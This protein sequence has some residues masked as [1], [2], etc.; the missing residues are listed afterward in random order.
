LIIYL[1]FKVTTPKGL[2]TSLKESSSKYEVAHWLEELARTTSTFKLAGS[3]PL[4]LEQTD[5]KVAKYLSYRKAHFKTLLTQYINLVGF[6]II[7]AAGL[8]VIGGLLVI[9]Q[10]MNIGQ[11]VASE[12][13][14]I[15]VLA[16]VEKLILS[17]ETIYDVLTAIEKIGTVTDI[18]LE[19]DVGNE[20]N[21]I[22]DEGITIRLKNISYQFQQGNQP[23]LNNIS[24]ELKAGEHL[25]ISGYNGSGKSILLQT[26]AGLFNSFSG[27][28]SFNNIPLKSLSKE[29]LRSHIGDNLSK[30]DIFIGSLLDNITLGKP[31]ISFEEVTQI[32]SILNLTSFIESLPNGYQTQLLTEG[33][34]L[35][36][37]VRLKLMLARG[38]IGNPRLL[39]LDDSFNQLP[40]EDKHRFINYLFANDK[41][42]TI[43]AISND[44][45]IA[46]QFDRVIV[47][48]NGLLIANDTLNHLRKANWYNNVFQ[49]H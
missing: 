4:P 35:P 9:N 30:E 8:L 19:K 38:V 11:F 15:L 2:K 41:K 29:Y 42:W 18:P 17:I 36:K 31:N 43:I 10:Q 1:I 28:I 24:F 20:I 37:S 5:K 14:I 26:I 32:A 46:A 25:C 27:S 7:V 47:L 3:T 48:D 13:I 45:I 21:F 49:N 34:N 39:L 16:S 23:V 22:A 6:K 33:K 44:P 12:I 40:I